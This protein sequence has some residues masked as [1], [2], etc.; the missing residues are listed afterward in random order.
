MSCAAIS[1]CP[2]FG[3]CHVQ[4]PAAWNYSLFQLVL[5]NCIILQLFAYGPHHYVVCT[6]KCIQTHY[7]LQICTIISLYLVSLLDQTPFN[8]IS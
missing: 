8:G 2:L 3:S 6:C 5:L 1:Y 4:P 7:T